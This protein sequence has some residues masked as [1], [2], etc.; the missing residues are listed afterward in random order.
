MECS[1]VYIS[2]D[3]DEPEL[4]TEKMVK[5]RTNHVCSECGEKIHSG[6]QY[7]RT[8]GRWECDWHLYKTCNTCLEIRNAFFCE[9]WFYSNILSDLQDMIYDSNGD[10]SESCLSDLSPKA[11]SVVCD[12]IEKAWKYIED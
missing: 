7:E 9:G 6:Q 1:C 3:F 2:N 4:F 12:M 10:I 5:S 8:K 11:R